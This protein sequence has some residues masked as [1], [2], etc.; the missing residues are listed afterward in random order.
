VELE[1]LPVLVVDDN[2]TNR[3]ILTETLSHWRMTPTAVSGGSQALSELRRAAAT[4]SPFPL[5][6]LDALMPEMDGFTLA[7]EIRQDPG[8]AGATILM[9]SSADRSSHLARCRAL[10]VA[11]CLVKPIKQSELLDAILTALGSGPLEKRGA[12]QDEPAPR[13]GGGLRL[14]LAEDNEINQAV[15]V[16]MLQRRGHSV[17]VANNGRE[18]LAVLATAQFDAVLMDVQMPELDGLET[19]AAIRE[20]ERST[21][22]HLP[23][24][25]L[26]AHAMKGDRERCLAAGMD[27]YVTKPL[28]IGELCHVLA[29]VVPPAASVAPV[30]PAV[31]HQEQANGEPV[32]FDRQTALARVE[33]DLELLRRLVHLFTRQSA[34]LL[35]EIKAAVARGDGPA[36]ERA[37]HKLKGSL[38]NLGAVKAA[39][40]AGRLE[41]LGRRGELATAGAA[42]AELE[43]DVAR[44]RSA[45]AELLQEKADED[46]AGR[47]R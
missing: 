8:L 46:L 19:T 35:D 18:A 7:E 15:A 39:A 42:G 13:A 16:R 43:R 34:R 11:G 33:G 24:V 29:R 23:I 30:S 27:D 5:V 10:G 40:A 41:V 28:R 6:L 45:L 25:A 1:R 44:L 20:G 14:L 9:L 32:V 21:G 37:A 3:N 22:R 2:A 36:L 26:T 31:Q 38:G 12:V 47:R 4:G 17:V